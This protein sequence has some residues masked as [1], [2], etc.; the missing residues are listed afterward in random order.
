M[1]AVFTKEM[2]HTHTILLP[3]MLPVH[4]GL[5]QTVFALNGY[6]TELLTKSDRAVVDE[7][8][9][10][11]HN[12]TCYPALLVIGQ[13]I[14]ALKS[15]RFNPDKIAVMISQTGGGC[16]AS[17]YLHLLRKALETEFPQI[18]VLSINFSGLERDSGFKITPKMFIQ[19]LYCVLYGDILMNVRNHT[20][21]YEIHKG[22]TDSKLHKWVILIE[23][24]LKSGH[25]KD[26]KRYY[27]AIL[28]D[29]AKIPLKNEKKPKV[30]IV[31]EIYVKYSPLANNHLED[32]L[33]SEGAEPIVPAFL[34]F[35]MYCAVNTVND[36]IIYNFTDSKTIIFKAAY[37]FLLRKQREMIRVIKQHGQF[38]VPHDFEELRSNADKYFHQGVKMGEGWLIPAETAALMEHGVPNVVLTQPFG[39]LPNHIVA[40]GM[41]RTIRENYPEANVVAV[42]YDPGA[43]KVNLENRIKLMLANIRN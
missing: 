16:R 7:G 18:P 36:G 34:D 15:G 29:F 6:K 23:R 37:L 30:G 21:T 8:L 41:M 3:D 5:I 20:R 14:D 17:N 25:Y 43:T 1:P 10:H 11:V 28:E 12:D 26:T 32:F 4:F 31:G 9:Q 42:D 40:K 27:N 39:C 33:I 35:C 38:E 13:F 2:K 19:M 22:D 24:A